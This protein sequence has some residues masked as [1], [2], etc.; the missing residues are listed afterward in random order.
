MD[1]NTSKYENLSANLSKS[2]QN[3]P[4]KRL[5]I[6]YRIFSEFTKRLFK[7]FP[8]RK[9]RIQEDKTDQS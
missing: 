9:E 7:I 5:K 6:F 1:R 2:I 8:D 3:S 4:Q